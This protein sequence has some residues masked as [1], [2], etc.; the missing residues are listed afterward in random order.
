M[1]LHTIIR[2]SQFGDGLVLAPERY[3]PR[4]NVLLREPGDKAAKCLGELVSLER[5]TVSASRPFPDVDLYVILDTCDAREGAIVSQKKPVR[6]SEIGSAK[7]VIRPGDVIVSRLRP[8]LRQVAF[9]DDDFVRQWENAVLIG[10][11]EFMVLR[12]MDGDDIAYL[13]PYLLT[14]PV[15]AVLNASQEG[16]HHPRFNSSTLLQLPVPLSLVDSRQRIS[17]AVRKSV[18]LLRSSEGTFA[19]ALTACSSEVEAS[20]AK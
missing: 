18:S 12:A 20:I 2:S 17:E 8:Y 9:V 1:A 7:K 3:D 16:G 10:S 15:Q 5:Q 4:R 14:E 19:E 6:G 11:T 13:A